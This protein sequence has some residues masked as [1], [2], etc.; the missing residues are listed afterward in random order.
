[1][2]LA[3]LGTMLPAVRAQQA[4]T[5]PPEQPQD[6]AVAASKVREIV[7]HR[8]SSADRPENT[9]AAYER[10]IDAGATAI[11]ADIRQSTDGH[12][13]SLHDAELAR[14]T[15]GKGIAEHFTLAELQALDAGAWFGE[16]FRGERIPTLREICELANGRADLFLDLKDGDDRYFTAVARDLR[17]HGDPRRTLLGV[18][19]LAAARYFRQHLPESRQVGLLPNPSDLDLFL[20]EG[21]RIIRLWPH[22]INPPD[23]DRSAGDQLI[24]RIR[25]A[26]AQIL[27]SAGKGTLP[28]TEAILRASPELVFTDDPAALLVTLRQLQR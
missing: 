11:E 13:F 12:L 6:L 21:I 23:G 19:S 25:A 7:A 1:V 2:L 4:A 22:W 28:E 3:I 26:D 10:A 8:G 24:A 15:N 5:R 18:R 14:T 17:R 20:G 9:L 16:S 27:V